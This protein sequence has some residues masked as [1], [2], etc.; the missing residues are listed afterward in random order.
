MTQY[1]IVLQLLIPSFDFN[2]YFGFHCEKRQDI[3]IQ[4][5]R[6]QGV[7][8]VNSRQIV[9]HNLY[10]RLNHGALIFWPFL[11]A[12]AIHA[13]VAFRRMHHL[14]LCVISNSTAELMIYLMHPLFFTVNI[15]VSS[16]ILT[17]TLTPHF[18]FPENIISQVHFVM[19]LLTIDRNTSTIVS[20]FAGIQV[21][22]IISVRSVSNTCSIERMGTKRAKI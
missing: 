10:P 4:H 6:P 21:L 7:T 18:F 17:F 3:F 20:L 13:T 22:S 14:Y 2:S 9:I 8:R 11:S 15:L 5:T 12:T 1:C 16:M 19:I